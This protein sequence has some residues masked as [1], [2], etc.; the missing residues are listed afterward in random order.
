VQAS[1]ATD[2]REFLKRLYDFTKC[3]EDGLPSGDA[4]PE[5]IVQGFDDEQIWQE[6]ELQNEARSDGLVASVASLVAHKDRLKFPVRLKNEERESDDMD[7]GGELQKREGDDISHDGL[8]ST[9]EN[10]TD[11]TADKGSA[12]RKQKGQFAVF[13]SPPMNLFCVVLLCNELFIHRLGNNAC[14]TTLVM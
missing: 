3:V 6:L 13:L 14:P 8:L 1:V 10:E 7:S 5:L 12:I 4:L 11:M 2:V 9:P